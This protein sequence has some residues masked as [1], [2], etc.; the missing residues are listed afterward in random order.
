MTINFFKICV[1]R[2]MW[3]YESNDEPVDPGILPVTGITF[4]Y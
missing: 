3:C 4:L 1:I 2:E